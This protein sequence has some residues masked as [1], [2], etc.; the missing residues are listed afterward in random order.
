MQNISQR[1]Q[2]AVPYQLPI[3]A[4]TIRP[5]NSISGI[6]WSYST[7]ADWQLIW[8]CALSPLGDI[9]HVTKSQIYLFIYPSEYGPREILNKVNR[10]DK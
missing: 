4:S 8:H 9:L 6:I 3:G 1:T 2:G 5:N 10:Y 7:S